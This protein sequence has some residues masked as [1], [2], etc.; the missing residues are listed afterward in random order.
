MFGCPPDLVTGVHVRVA[1]VAVV[2]M[3]VGSPIGCCERL[4]S[5]VSAAGI[6]AVAV[7]LGRPPLYHD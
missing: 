2:V 1:S 6:P 4:H 3:S 7:V 5:V